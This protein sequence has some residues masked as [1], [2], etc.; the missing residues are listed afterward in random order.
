MTGHRWLRQCRGGW[1]HI[2]QSRSAPKEVKSWRVIY[3]CLLQDAAGGRSVHKERIWLTSDC[4]IS[5]QV[6]LLHFLHTGHGS[7]IQTKPRNV[8]M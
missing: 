5:P 2:S 1:L 7:S 4:A 6:H 8:L 3:V